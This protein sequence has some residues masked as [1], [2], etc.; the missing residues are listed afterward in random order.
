[1][2]GAP[3][4]RAPRR[5]GSTNG[6]PPAHVARL[7][8]SRRSTTSLLVGCRLQPSC[9][10]GAQSAALSARTDD[11]AALTLEL[12][13]RNERPH[14]GTTPL[15]S[16]KLARARAQRWSGHHGQIAPARPPATRRGAPNLPLR[17]PQSRIASRG[18]SRAPLSCKITRRVRQAH[19]T[20]QP[21]SVD[22]SQLYPPATTTASAFPRK[23]K[24]CDPT[25][26][27]S[28]AEPGP[29]RLVV[30]DHPQT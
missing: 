5:C 10:S 27:L 25:N 19:S 8:S 17:D 11:P 21:R 14:P 1:V 6:S 15:R 29:R 20:V 23:L 13:L 18:R 7:V 30:P 16:K 4:K 24:V 9:V 26:P 22:H 3:C 2:N 28:L 12:C